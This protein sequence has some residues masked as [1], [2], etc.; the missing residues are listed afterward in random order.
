MNK[1]C[2]SRGW[3]LVETLII[4]VIGVG[5]LVAACVI[6][7]GGTRH[8]HGV[9]QMKDSTQLRSIQQAMVAWANQN[10]GD[11]PLPSLIDL[12]DATV[13]E[14]G[15]AKDH[16]ANILSTL[17]YYGHISTELAVS[18]AE[19]HTAAIEQD[20][21]YELD[22]PKAAADPTKALW[23][24]A[25]SADFTGGKIGNT[26][27]AHLL[28][29]GPR[30]T[31]W[32]DT[33]ATTQPIIGNRGPEIAS[34]SRGKKGRFT[35]EYANPDTYTFLIHGSRTSWEGNIAYNDGHVYFETRLDP[36]TIRYRTA[37]KRK[38]SDCLFHDEPD[39]AD[40]TNAFLGIFT[41]AGDTKIDFHAIWD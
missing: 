12:N 15:A 8:H 29:A 1:Q 37:D 7:D 14:K 18:W 30:R 41:T 13:R 32:R 39:D 34:Y 20:Q 11:F 22:N 25:F 31:L 5:V 4:S 27:Y 23:D 17:I 21:D 33:F 38:L 36:D 9:R 40:G 24:P 10:N 28:P 6:L 16:T 3:T 19:S 2:C 26:S 35:P